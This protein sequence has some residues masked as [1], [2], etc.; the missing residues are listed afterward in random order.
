MNFDFELDLKNVLHTEFDIYQIRLP[1]RKSIRECLLDYLTVR[2]KLVYPKRRTVFLNP[3]L[4]SELALHPQKKEIKIIENSLKVGRD[5]NFF[6]NKR[7]FQTN[8]HDHLCYEWN[9]FHF[10]LS[11]EK[12]RKSQ[13]YKQVKQLLYVYI[14]DEQAILLGTDNHTK[15]SFGDTKWL[16]IL[17]DHFPEILA[18]FKNDSIKEIYPSVN[19]IDRQTLWD[20]GY[21]LA[22]TNIRG[23]IYH[24]PGVGRVTTGHSLMVFKVSLRDFNLSKPRSLRL[25]I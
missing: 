22:M 11:L 13:F 16:E 14:N 10:H 12:E 19:S 5:V 7:L 18:P 2:K 4:A 20:K 1:I 6:Q 25:E 15:G 3:Q 21:T 8:F 23:N 9:I 24:N 17:H